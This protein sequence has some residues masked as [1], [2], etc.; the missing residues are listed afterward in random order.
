MTDTNIAMRPAT[1]RP[2]PHGAPLPITVLPIEVALDG[3]QYLH[4]VRGAGARERSWNLARHN[5]RLQLATAPG[6]SMTRSASLH[7]TSKKNGYQKQIK[8]VNPWAF[9]TQ[10]M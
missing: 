9:A 6:L 7:E 10:I 4:G 5:W 1:T 2:L 8:G 3:R